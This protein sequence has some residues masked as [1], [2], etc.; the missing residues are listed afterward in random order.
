MRLE[1]DDGTLLL[2]NTPD[3]MPYVEWDDRVDEYRAQAYRYQASSTGLEQGQRGTNRSPSTMAFLR[4]LRMLPPPIQSSLSRPPSISNRGTTSKPPLTHGSSTTAR[5]VSYSRRAAARRFLVSRPSPTIDLMNQWHATLTNAFGDQLTEPVGVLGGGSHDVTA[6]TVTTYDSAYRYINEYGDQFGL[7]V[8]DE[9][10]HLPA[11]TYQQIPEMTIAP[12]IGPMGTNS[13]GR[14]FPNRRK[15][16][17]PG[18]R[19]RPAAWPASVGCCTSAG[20]DSSRATHR[21]AGNRGSKTRG[22]P[23]MGWTPSP[24]D[25]VSR[26]RWPGCDR[27][28][29]NPD[30]DIN[31]T[32]RHRATG[33]NDDRDEP[34]SRSLIKGIIASAEITGDD[35]RLFTFS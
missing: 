5:A 33:R 31:A 22:S 32:A 30:R 1:F 24:G 6:I 3:E 2:R 15:T 10:H 34:R 4:L 18:S 12:S 8:V 29:R 9:E 23:G 14:P 21:S 7:L 13:G 19:F 35:I 16:M 25:S 26:R 20:P 17:D 27:R 28:N 11:P